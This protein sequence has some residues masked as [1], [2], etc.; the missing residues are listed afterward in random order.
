MMLMKLI[1]CTEVFMWS[2][3]CLMFQWDVTWCLHFDL[4]IWGVPREEGVGQGRPHR[5]PP[6]GRAPPAMLWWR[7]QG[8]KIYWRSC[9]ISYTRF[10]YG[11]VG[12]VPTVRRACVHYSLRSATTLYFRSSQVSC[13]HCTFSLQMSWNFLLTSWTSSKFY[14]T[15]Q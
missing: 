1:I 12:V 3:S 4:P 11:I 8:S 7:S 9:I 15:K 6:L 14:R 2:C 5:A 13:I 10:R